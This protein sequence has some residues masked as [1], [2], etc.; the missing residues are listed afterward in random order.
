MK[1]KFINH[2]RNV[3]DRAVTLH[4][5]VD[6]FWFKY[7]YMEEMVRCTY[8]TYIHSPKNPLIHSDTYK[9]T[10]IRT[11]IHIGMMYHVHRVFVCIYCWCSI[12]KCMYVSMM[13]VSAVDN[14]RQVFERWMKWE[15]DDLAWAAFIKFEM[16]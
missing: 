11:Y 1:N 13:K 7:S 2:A 8:C 12:F 4:P 14:A 15:P 10:N 3:W 16:R 9:H 5:R 6:S